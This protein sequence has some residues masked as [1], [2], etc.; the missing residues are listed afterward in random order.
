MAVLV[1]PF[2]VVGSVVR[3]LSCSNAWAKRTVGVLYLPLLIALVLVACVYMIEPLGLIVLA[4]GAGPLA[5]PLIAGCIVAATAIGYLSK[6]T[7][8][9]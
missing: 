2:V 1:V 8:S 9:T 3:V 4:L 5:I 7:P 6:C